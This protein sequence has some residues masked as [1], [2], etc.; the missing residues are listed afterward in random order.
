MRQ[1]GD[2][3]GSERLNARYAEAAP[4]VVIRVLYSTLLM[5]KQ[6]W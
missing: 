4:D 3:N 5:E 1:S 6:S 2:T